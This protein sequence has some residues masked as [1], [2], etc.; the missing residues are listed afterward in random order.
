MDMGLGKTISTLTA[1][2]ELLNEFEVRRMLVVA[3]LRVARKVWS[4]EVNEWSHTQGLK[5]AHIVGT[6]AERVKALRTPA[7]IHCINR[8]QMMW[9]EAQFIEGKKQLRRWPWDVVVLDES[10]SFKN[11]TSQRTLSMRRL[12]KLCSRLVLLTGTPIPNGLY[13]LFAQFYLL[14]RGVRLGMNEKAFQQRWF[15]CDMADGR[16][17]WRP[18]ATAMQE[19][20]RQ[21]ADITLS[22]RAEDYLT[23][24]P[25]KYN[26][27]RVQMSASAMAKY[28]ELERKF[29]LEL[30]GKL[31]TAVNAGIVQGK[32]LQ[33][34]NGAVYD[35][36]RAWH[37]LHNEKLEA[38][39]ET[40]EF[41]PAPVLVGYTYRHDL[42]RISKLLET[43]YGPQGARWSVLRSDKSF[44][45]W[46]QGKYEIGV[47]HPASAGHGLNDV[48]KSGAENLIHFGYTNNLEW[49]QQLN[50]RLIGGHRR[51]G[52]NVVIHRIVCDDTEDENAGQLLLRKD[53]TQNDF[54]RALADRV[55]EVR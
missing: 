25:V 31:I 4:D 42:E 33:L 32:L 53:V 14:D 51:V 26:H 41:L 1:F 24:P 18:R 12:R 8:E 23:L 28:K 49:D 40:L 47:L 11:F 29:L 20:L 52:R 2:V 55:K 34:A 3:P 48:Y 9:L 38:L 21:V 36:E 16:V 43:Q 37:V 50:A 22:L 44:S 6:A 54:T 46:A 19:I 5:V 10:Q 7:D 45:E 27:I 30:D 35:S 15:D 39:S 17:T 13:D